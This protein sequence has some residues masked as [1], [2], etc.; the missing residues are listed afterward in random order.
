[1]SEVQRL[2]PSVVLGLHDA[3]GNDVVGAKVSLDGQPLADRLDGHAIDVDPGEHTLQFDVSGRAPV[4][5]KVVI[6]EGE[7]GREILVTMDSSPP[8]PES[9]K[10]EPPRSGVPT[11]SWVLGGLSAAAFTA[12][13]YFALTGYSRWSDCHGGGCGAGDAS[14]VDR[15][16]VAADVT[17]IVGALAGGLA[18]Y[19]YFTRPT[20]RYRV[21]LA[22][23][24]GTVSADFTF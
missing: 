18:T 4:K 9:A 3:G 10:A 22:V 16:W 15:Q 1:L 14:Y 19:F 6:R 11:V 23:R 20:D 21:G 5:Q 12:F 13:G 8:T 7:K 24:A 2:I 17:L